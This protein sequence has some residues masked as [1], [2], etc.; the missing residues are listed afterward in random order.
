M[1]IL[2]CIDLILK[3]FDFL[4]SKSCTILG[5]MHFIIGVAASLGI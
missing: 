4:R 1:L 2:F 5:V 3:L